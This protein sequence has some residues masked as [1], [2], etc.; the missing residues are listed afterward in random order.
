VWGPAVLAG[1]EGEQTIGVA[2]I[3]ESLCMVHRSYRPVE[4]LLKV[5]EQLLM[6]TWE[7]RRRPEQT[8]DSV[9]GSAGVSFMM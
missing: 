5:A 8:L 4:S 1:L 7:Q 6:S 9:S 2:T 3:N